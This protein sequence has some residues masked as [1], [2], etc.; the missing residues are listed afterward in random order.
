M[1]YRPP[2]LFAFPQSSMLV[3]FFAP[4][5][6]SQATVTWYFDRAI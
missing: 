5:I 2:L 4:N 1:Q 3:G 6:T